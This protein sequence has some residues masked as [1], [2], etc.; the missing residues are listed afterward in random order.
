MRFNV[1]DWARDVANGS[2]TD[3]G[4]MLRSIT[5]NND[6]YA[7]FMGTYYG[8][9]SYRPKFV[10]KYT[11]GPSKA[12]SVSTE[13][14][15]VKKGASIRVSWKGIKATGLSHVQYRVAKVDPS[16]NK[17]TDENYVA[18]TDFSSSYTASSGTNVPIPG[19]SSFP[20]GKYRIYVRGIDSGGIKGTGA[21]ANV[22]VDGTKPSISRFRV[23]PETSENEYTGVRTPEL[24]WN[25]SE[26]YLS[27]VKVIVDDKEAAKASIKDANGYKLPSGVIKE[28]GVHKIRITVV[29]K[30]GNAVS[31]DD[32]NY[33]LDIDPPVIESFGS[34]PVTDAGSM[35]G[36][37]RS[38]SRF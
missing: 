12:S 13:R 17:I 6:T 31:T 3:Y 8:T 4:L 1:T 9:E 11:D 7:R 28:S 24:S 18:Y 33:Y 16:A 27:E 14:P 26:K 2:R 37:A 15:Y 19:S 5:E 21:G 29:D 34:E 23:E 35:S 36:D 30:A 25:I 10:L 20:E 32:R 38:D 22:Y